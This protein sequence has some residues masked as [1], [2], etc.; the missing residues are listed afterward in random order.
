MRQNIKIYLDTS[1]YVKGFNEEYRSDVIEEIVDKCGQ[2]KF[3]KSYLLLH[4]LK[5]LERQ[6]NRAFP[7]VVKKYFDNALIGASNL[8][9]VFDNY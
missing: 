2:G 1:A 6:I 5:G 7:E 8:K 3:P 9:R 4:S